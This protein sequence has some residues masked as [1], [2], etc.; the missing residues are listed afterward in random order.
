ME[1]H[2]IGLFGKY[3]ICEE[4]C[5][6]DYG[7]AGF[8]AMLFGMDSSIISGVVILPAFME[9]VSRIQSIY[10][11]LIIAGGSVSH[12][13]K[14]IRSFLPTCRRTLFPLCKLAALPELLLRATSPTC[15]VERRV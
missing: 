3:S 14:S 12:Q 1:G 7:Q 5:E 11:S 2:R 10:T 4:V 6:A 15:L 13:M 8:G 9:Y